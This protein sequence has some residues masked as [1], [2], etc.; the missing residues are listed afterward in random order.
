MLVPPVDVGVVKKIVARESPP[1]PVT[2]VGALGTV[3]GTSSLL[4]V[5][6]EL[7]P[8]QATASA[9]R[10]VSWNM[11]IRSKARVA[12]SR[13]RGR[14][15]HTLYDMGAVRAISTA[16]APRQ[17]DGGTNDLCPCRRA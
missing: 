10:M 8:A 11:R 9:A 13:A 3:V 1:L 16:A 5:G 17:N 6:D 14:R 15:T 7:S 12:V 4:P 2:P